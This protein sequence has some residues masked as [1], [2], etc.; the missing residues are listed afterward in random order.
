MADDNF[1]VVCSKQ[2]IILRKNTEKQNAYLISFQAHATDEKIEQLQKKHLY[3]LI[4]D[5][6]PDIILKN[7]VTALDDGG[8][9]VM[10]LFARIG[11]E[12]G[13]SQ[14]CLYLNTYVE[15]NTKN[16]LVVRGIGPP[17][18]DINCEYDIVNAK[19]ID[20]CVNIDKNKLVTLHFSFHLDLNED[21]PSYMQDLPGLLM[22]KILMGLKKYI[23]GTV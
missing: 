8:H 7:K 21:L 2:D 20:M 14:K 11:K 3:Q 10:F 15:T 17:A 4:G 18:S 23:E 16:K 9:S 1:K 22:L 13:L 6:C 19:Y 5:L 12:L